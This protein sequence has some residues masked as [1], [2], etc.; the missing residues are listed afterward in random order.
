MGSGFLELL[1]LT[2]GMWEILEERKAGSQGRENL[3]QGVQGR[4]ARISKLD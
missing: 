4:L 3:L 2:R 1:T